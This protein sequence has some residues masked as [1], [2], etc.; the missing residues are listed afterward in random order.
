MGKGLVWN[1]VSTTDTPVVFAPVPI[2]SPSALPPAAGTPLP[3]WPEVA[4][5]TTDWSDSEVIGPDVFRFEYFYMLTDGSLKE[6][7]DFR[8]HLVRKRLAGRHGD[9]GGNRGD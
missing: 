5:S 4:S 6:F 9:C 1:G 2:A 8:Q 7:R 3:A